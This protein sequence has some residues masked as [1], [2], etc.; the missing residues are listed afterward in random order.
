[1]SD[2]KKTLAEKYAAVA[3]DRHF[4][5]P[6]YRR[7]LD[8]NTLGQYYGGVGNKSP[9][10]ILISPNVPQSYYGSEENLWDRIMKHELAHAYQTRRAAEHKPVSPNVD[11][12]LNP[13]SRE[14]LTNWEALKYR[15]ALAGLLGSK[16]TDAYLMSGTTDLNKSLPSDPASQRILQKSILDAIRGSGGGQEAKIWDRK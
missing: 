3:V 12:L 1:M 13:L 16:E 14:F 11:T 5:I 9:E 10:S 6:V 8:E 15:H 2:K 4:K 7:D